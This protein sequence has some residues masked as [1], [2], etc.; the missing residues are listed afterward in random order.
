MVRFDLPAW[1]L[2]CRCGFD[3]RCGWCIPSLFSPS[4]GSSSTRR[5]QLVEQ[6]V[7]IVEPTG[8][9]GFAF[10]PFR[11][12]VSI[13]WRAIAA[14]RDRRVVACAWLTIPACR[15]RLVACHSGLPWPSRGSPFR[16]AV[17]SRGSPFRLAVV[18]AW[19]AIPACRGRRVVYR[20]RHPVQGRGVLAVDYGAMPYASSSMVLFA[21]RRSQCVIAGGIQFRGTAMLVI[22]A[23]IVACAV[24]RIRHRSVVRRSS[25]DLRCIFVSSWNVIAS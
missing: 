9:W 3:C 22:V 13:A 12:V 1:H 16:L 18:V 10:L 11:L 24:F 4:H 25:F 6:P 19:L 21:Y 7:D 23:F 8:G 5:A 17:V 2:I 14:R 15:G 20:S